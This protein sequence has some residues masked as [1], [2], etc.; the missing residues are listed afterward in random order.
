MVP[1]EPPATCA[2]AVDRG[3]GAAQV[4]VPP[5]DPTDAEEQ[6][7]LTAEIGILGQLVKVGVFACT[8]RLQLLPPEMTFQ[9]TLAPAL[10]ATTG[11]TPGLVALKL[12]VGGVTV[13]VKLAA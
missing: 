9:L 6:D 10:P 13:T 12:M 7:T 4:A 2:A 8:F 11:L 1:S 3:K 5:T